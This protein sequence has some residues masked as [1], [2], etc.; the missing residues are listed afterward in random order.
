MPV[1]YCRCV[2]CKNLPDRWKRTGVGSC[3]KCEINDYSPHLSEYYNPNKDPE[4]IN[5][6]FKDYIYTCIGKYFLKEFLYI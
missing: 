1:L 2:S 4:S 3:M 6:R 5:R